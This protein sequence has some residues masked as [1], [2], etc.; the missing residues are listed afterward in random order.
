MKSYKSE[1]VSFIHQLQ[2]TICTAIEEQDGTA[3]FIQENW[4]RPGGGGGKT[5]V[6]SNG[7]VIEK[8][9]VNI[10]EVYG[11]LPQ[12]MQDYLKIESPGPDFR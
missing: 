7:S 8:G 3:K 2:D 6:I 1:F 10:S 5:R 11:V 4:E 9:G 12:S